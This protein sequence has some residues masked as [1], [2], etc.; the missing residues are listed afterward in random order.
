MRLLVG[1][2]ATALDAALRLAAPGVQIAIAGRELAPLLAAVLALRT[3]G[4]EVWG[5]LLP[6]DDDAQAFAASARERWGGD[7]DQRL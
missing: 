5:E 7:F 6:A 4:A 3:A 2:A 1:D